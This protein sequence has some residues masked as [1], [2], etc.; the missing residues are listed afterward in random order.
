VYSAA[1]RVTRNS[2]SRMGIEEDG[3]N[4]EEDSIWMKLI[5]RHV[6]T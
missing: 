4:Y 1:V 2:K 3:E 5:M 6:P